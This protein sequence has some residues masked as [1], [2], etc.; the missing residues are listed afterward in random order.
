[1]QLSELFDQF[2][3]GELAQVEL[4]GGEDGEITEKDFPRLIA[5]VNLGLMALYTRFFLKESAVLVQLQS[6]KY[7]YYL[8]PIYAVSNTKSR[9][10]LL[11]RHILDSTGDRFT[12]GTLL[13]VEKIHVFKDG[14]RG[15][16]LPLNQDF[17][18][19][20]IL[21]PTMQSI[22]VPS[23]LVN[24]TQASTDVPEAWRTDQ[25]VVTYR[26]AHP[27]LAVGL[28]YFD[29]ERI[30]LEIPPT[31]VEALCYFVASR[32]HNPIGMSNEF[33]AGN[34]YSARYEAKCAELEGAGMQIS[35]LAQMDRFTS[36][37]FV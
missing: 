36:K 35:T 21:T 16:E 24:S 26:A 11:D 15:E 27:K 5:N 4:G 33:H 32:I 10:P 14:K 34:N 3:H 6:S 22:Y 12:A 7:T 37:G 1:M 30:T 29:P 13:R 20:S 9:I 17:E 8:D 18:D 28:G 19:L 31:H 23:A 25:V 2:K